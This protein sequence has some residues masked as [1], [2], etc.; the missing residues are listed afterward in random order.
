[1]ARRARGGTLRVCWTDSVGGA[2]GLRLAC[3]LNGPT[4][5]DAYM[6]TGVYLG[7]GFS[8]SRGKEGRPSREEHQRFWHVRLA[9]I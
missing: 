9:V 4:T 2:R 8:F 1:M 7:M 6:G 5:G 3:A